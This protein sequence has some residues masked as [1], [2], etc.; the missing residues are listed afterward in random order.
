MCR[1]GK[2]LDILHVLTLSLKG[3]LGEEEMMNPT[4][5]MW[6]NAMKN[7][8]GWIMK[9]DDLKLLRVL[10]TDWWM[11]GQTDICN[12]RVAFTTEKEQVSLEQIK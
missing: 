1:F 4:I 6:Q 7:D 12:C 3:G 10:L 11:D 2:W 5:V 8:E 9:D